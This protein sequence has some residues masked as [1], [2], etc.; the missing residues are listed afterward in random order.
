ME[1]IVCPRCNEMGSAKHIHSYGE[2][3]NC[4]INDLLEKESTE[5]TSE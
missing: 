3:E 5:S 4:T 1:K 2:C